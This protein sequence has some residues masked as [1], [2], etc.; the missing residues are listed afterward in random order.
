MIILHSIEKVEKI[1][2]HTLLGPTSYIIHISKNKPVYILKVYILPENSWWNEL[3]KG[4]LL[5][6][7]ANTFFNF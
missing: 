7:F 1:I 2:L 3:K 6:I 5:L 4:V